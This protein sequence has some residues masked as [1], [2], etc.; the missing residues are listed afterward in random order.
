MDSEAATSVKILSYLSICLLP[1]FNRVQCSKPEEINI[2]MRL[3]W[4]QWL[5]C[6]GIAIVSWPLALLENYSGLETHHWASSE[7]AN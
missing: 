4:P 1:N 3:S 7:S 6:L 5:I 2:F